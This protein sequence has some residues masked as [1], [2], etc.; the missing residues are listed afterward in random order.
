VTAEPTTI[1]IVDDEPGLRDFVGVTLK[2]AGFRV[3]FAP[4]GAGVPQMVLHAK[5]QLVVMDLSMPAVS[6]LEAL[7]QLRALGSTVPVVMLT[8]RDE[9][10]AR[11]SAFDAGADDY[12]LKPFK[13]RELVARVTAVLRRTQVKPSDA[14]PGLVLCIGDLTLVPS[15]HSANVGGRE[16]VL[17][18]TE[19]ALLLTLARAAGRVFTPAELL[20][21]VWGPEYCDQAEILRTNM[22][23]LR[24]KL[25]ANPRQP[26]H[27]RTRTGVGYYLAAA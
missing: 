5:P 19:Y 2:L 10:D 11:Y 22:Y 20:S 8:G 23:R 7:R 3:L 25:E 13:A 9:D 17:T 26:R 21:R 27:L 24:Q 14:D 12:L 1:L 4:D 15:N 6:G 16:V 18:R